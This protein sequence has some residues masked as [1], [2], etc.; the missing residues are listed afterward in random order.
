M[1]LLPFQVKSEGGSSPMSFHG[2]VIKY[3]LNCYNV[4]ITLHIVLV[5]YQKSTACIESCLAI[6]LCMLFNTNIFIVWNL[7]HKL[8]CGKRVQIDYIHMNSCEHR[9][10]YNSLRVE[11]MMYYLPLLFRVSIQCFQLSARLLGA[12]IAIRG[13][14]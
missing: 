3:Q 6:K 11:I 4:M 2:N 8:L 14:G 12:Q 13:H 5:L 10:I 7:S 1:F 9:E